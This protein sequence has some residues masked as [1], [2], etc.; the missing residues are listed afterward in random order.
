MNNLFDSFSPQSLSQWQQQLT[1]DL[2]GQSEDLLKRHDAIEEVD[3]TTYQHAESPLASPHSVWSEK[4]ARGLQKESNS[5]FNVKTIEVK[6][7]KEANLVAINALNSGA[8]SIRFV[9]QNDVE[10]SVLL[11]NIQLEVIQTRLVNPSVQL[12]QTIASNYSTLLGSNLL[13]EWDA[14]QIATYYDAIQPILDKKQFPA[15]IANG[16]AVQ[17]VGANTSQEVAFILTAA[18][19]ALCFLME[20]GMTVDQAAACIHLQVGAGQKYFF[21][22]AKTR[23]LR[24]LWSKIIEAYHPVSECSK[25]ITILGLTGFINKSIKDPHT[26]LLRQT[27]EVSSLILGGADAISC[28]PHDLYST[29]GSSVLAN[30]MALNIPNI[31]VEESYFDKVIDPYAGSY[32]VEYLSNTI[33]DKAWGMFSQFNASNGF[34][35]EANVETFRN[36]LIEKANLRKQLFTEGKAKFIGVNTFPNPEKVDGKWLST[37]S[38]LGLEFLVYERVEG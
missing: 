26:N 24:M 13:I 25:N 14:L 7:A 12:V 32:A 33:A 1:K 36:L 22:I 30:R 38:Y 31:L 8:N 17:Q 10:I 2:K 9:L 35:N 18:H 20:K 29:S 21:E 4:Y 15:F 6:D 19:D 28:Q 34:S 23:V 37:G 27:T 11:D 16:Y 5:F 3:Y